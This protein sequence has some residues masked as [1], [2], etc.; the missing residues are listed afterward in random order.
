M[1]LMVDVVSLEE[2][3]GRDNKSD[4]P[5]VVN[6]KADDSYSLAWREFFGEYNPNKREGKLTCENNLNC[7]SSFLYFVYSLH[8]IEK[9]GFLIHACSLIRNNNGY[10]FS[11]KSGAGKTTIAQLSTDS[12][13]LS[14]EISLIKKIDGKFFMYGTPF[15]GDL[16]IPGENVKSTIKGIYFHK[17][18]K[19][20]Q[21]KNLSPSRTLEQLL[22]NVV[23][24]AQ[25]PDLTTKLFELCSDFTENIPGYEL[26][27]LP[28][29]SF[30]EVI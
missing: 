19:E 6:N 20:N 10:I 21:V 9:D 12:Q 26:Y 15:F 28:E 25:V 18:S 29:P 8:L 17:K 24:F 27:F 22:T 5:I 1:K 13:L 14:D 30:W 2:L 3:D 16:R 11:G 4:D 7:L 23:F